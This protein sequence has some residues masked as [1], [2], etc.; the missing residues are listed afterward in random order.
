MNLI[1][2]LEMNVI[3]CMIIFMGNNRGLLLYLL[4]IEGLVFFYI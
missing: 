1:I 2:E 3:N 4:E